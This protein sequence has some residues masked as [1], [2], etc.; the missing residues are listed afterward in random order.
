MKTKR[1]V[2]DISKWAIRPLKVRDF[3]PDDID[4]LVE[5]GG[6]QADSQEMRIIHKFGPAFIVEAPE[7]PIFAGGMVEHH[8]GVGAAWCVST[9]LVDLYPRETYYYARVLMDV[10]IERLRVKKVLCYTDLDRKNIRFAE[11]MGFERRCMLEGWFGE[12]D[13]CMLYQVVE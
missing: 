7:G 12:E 1:G 9:A 5:L 3:T 2:I 6:I 13:A 4:T 10:C 11:R 8:K